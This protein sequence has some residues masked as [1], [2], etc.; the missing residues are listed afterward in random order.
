MVYSLHEFA[1]GSRLSS[2]IQAK[3]TK[4]LYGDLTISTNLAATSSPQSISNKHATPPPLHSL[5][6]TDKEAMP[7]SFTSELCKTPTPLTPISRFSSEILFISTTKSGSVD[8]G[9]ESGG[10]SSSIT[11]VESPLPAISRV[12]TI[13]GRKR[14][15]LAVS[16]CVTKVVAL[17]IAL[18]LAVGG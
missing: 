9:G 10:E 2:T 5:T 1:I 6:P 11:T 18:C 3:I 16:V 12:R 17:V 8:D 14:T 4:F 13:V 15:K 7:T